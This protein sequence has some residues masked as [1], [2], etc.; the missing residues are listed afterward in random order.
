MPFIYTTPLLAGT[1]SD[2]CEDGPVCRICHASEWLDDL[3]VPAGSGSVTTCYYSDAALLSPCLC[4]GSVGWV[5]RGCL[6]H[7]RSE[8][9]QRTEMRRAAFCDVCK[10]PYR[11]EAPLSERWHNIQVVGEELWVPIAGNFAVLIVYCMWLPNPSAL[12]ERILDGLSVMYIGVLLGICA[13]QDAMALGAALRAD[14]W[15]GGVGGSV[16]YYCR[17]LWRSFK[18]KGPSPWRRSRRMRT[19]VSAD[20]EASGEFHLF[21]QRNLIIWNKLWDRLLDCGRAIDDQPSDCVLFLLG[22]L[23]PMLT[24]VVLAAWAALCSCSTSSEE[25]S[26]LQ[27]AFFYVGFYAIFLLG[28]FGALYTGVLFML[29]L[30][31]AICCPPARAQPGAA[32]VNLPVVRSLT[33]KERWQFSSARC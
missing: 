23:V 8:C 3:E 13:F 19:F 20:A 7:W 31:I 15:D 26:S 22:W 9:Y 5:H 12:K 2:E 6:D 24:A 11:Y 33:L 25:A 10:F 28:L 29:L 27:D 18:A 4:S 17:I 21:H 30:G 14:E 1:G 16:A 32:G